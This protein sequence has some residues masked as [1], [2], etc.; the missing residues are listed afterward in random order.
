MANKDK[1]NEYRIYPAV[2]HREE[3]EEDGYRV[4]FP[5]LPGCLTC[6][7]TLEEAFRMAKEALA[8]WL[9]SSE[10]VV[11]TPLENIVTE[12]TD[13]AML[14]EADSGDDIVYFKNTE[15]PRVFE[16]GL[17]KKGYT[18]YQVAQILGVDRGYI[19]HIIKGEKRPSVDM[20][21][22]MALLLDFDWHV[23]YSDPTPAI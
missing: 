12:G 1:D 18:K 22:R 2:F 13:R 5:D 21:K 20:A 23:F 19:T 16:E 4:D 14:V 17:E 7:K 9:D 8:L 6:G 11:P 3:R 15:V 10:P